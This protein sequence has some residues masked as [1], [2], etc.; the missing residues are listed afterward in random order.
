M[1]L[2]DTLNGQLTETAPMWMMRQAGRYLPEY[3]ELRSTSESF[4]H[5]CYTPDMAAEATLQ[6]I[7]RFDLDAAIIFSDILVIPDG[8][9][10]KTWFETGHGPRLEPLANEAQIEA[11]SIERMKEHLQPVYKAIT[12]TRMDLDESKALIGFCGAPFTLACYMLEGQSSKEWAVTRTLA[13]KAPQLFQT[14]IDKLIEACTEHLCAQVEAGVNAVQI[15][16]SWAGV[17]P[18]DQLMQWVIQPTRAIV[19]QFRE[20]YPHIPI[21]GFPRGVSLGYIPYCELVGVNALSLDTQVPLAWAKENLQKYVPVQGNLD[22]QLLAAS[23]EGMLARAEEILEAFLP[24]PFIFN[25]GHG[26]LPH[27]PIEHVEALVEKVRSTKRNAS[28][29]VG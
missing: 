24:K 3:R 15:F 14:L 12:Q 5:F 13:Y 6:P 25:L 7:H 11:L 26:I 10:Q 4:L 20:R 27:T 22:P 28:E 17:L 18:E 2:I 16:D 19:T 1:K 23:K 21:I 9:G 8:L 29:L